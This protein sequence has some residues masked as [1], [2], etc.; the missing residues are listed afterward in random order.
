MDS[1]CVCG[2]NM[3]IYS[4]NNAVLVIFSTILM[5]IIIGVK[6]SMIYLML[7]ININAT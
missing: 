2:M 3:S 5:Y 6:K 4:W 7:L 1:L